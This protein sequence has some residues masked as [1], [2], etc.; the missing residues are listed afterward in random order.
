MRPTSGL[1]MNYKTVAFGV[2]VG[3]CMR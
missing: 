1:P 3:R 2:R